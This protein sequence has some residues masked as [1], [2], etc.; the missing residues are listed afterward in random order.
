MTQHGV[1]DKATNQREAK[2]LR[3]ESFV[4]TAESDLYECKADGALSRTP[5]GRGIMFAEKFRA[6]RAEVWSFLDSVGMSVTELAGELHRDPRRLR[7]EL[8]RAR[9][10]GETVSI[11]RAWMNSLQFV[12]EHRV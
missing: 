7:R 5:S 10:G 11:V 2:V 8:S 4:R 9:P 6:T 3:I 1:L 12:I